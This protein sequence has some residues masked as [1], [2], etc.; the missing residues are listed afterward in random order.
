[1]F[2]FTVNRMKHWQKKY[3]ETEWKKWGETDFDY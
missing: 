2:L 3:T 1:M